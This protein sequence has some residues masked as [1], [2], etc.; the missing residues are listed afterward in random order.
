MASSKTFAL[1]FLIFAFFIP[2]VLADN[3]VQVRSQ[4]LDFYQSIYPTSGTGSFHRTLNIDSI[5]SDG[6][7][8][9]IFPTDGWISSY[10]SAYPSAAGRD[11]ACFGYDLPSPVTWG[12]HTVIREGFYN[13]PWEFDFVANGLSVT[14]VF[15]LQ[16]SYQPAPPSSVVLEIGG[17]IYQPKYVQSLNGSSGDTYT[18]SVD[19]DGLDRDSLSKL[20]FITTLDGEGFTLYNTSYLATGVYPVT[21]S[22]SYTTADIYA[23]ATNSI[24]KNQI[25]P[26]LQNIETIA[27]HQ[28][29]NQQ[30]INDSINNSSAAEMSQSA[31]Q[32]S[33]SMAAI[34]SLP[35]AQ[36]DAEL[37]EAEVR[38]SAAAASEAAQLADDVA[39]AEALIP[40]LDQVN[41]S[42][43]TFFSVFLSE[44][45]RS[46]ALEFPALYVPPMTGVSSNELSLS[47]KELIDF[48]YYID[49]IPP[50]IMLVVQIV[51]TGG[52]AIFMIKNMISIIRL[53]LNKGK[54]PIAEAFSPEPD[55]PKHVGFT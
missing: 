5:Y 52:C 35:S 28:M 41:S 2:S 51:V 19:L 54:D 42:A 40:T 7:L 24:I 13:I 33:E 16:G 1:V 32:H 31:A 4:T 10:T 30:I 37:D 12:P 36:A 45:D 26:S 55:P 9:Q 49:K 20:V 23:E 50:E 6:H 38:A 46:A 17:V 34:S 22:S 27:Q 47:D 11:H 15:H 53:I 29:E 25:T 44:N 43:S 18:F 48:N 39:A 8:V 3:V 14:Y 21:V